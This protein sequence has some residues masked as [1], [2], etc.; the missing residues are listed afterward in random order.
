M[1]SAV[2]LGGRY[3]DVHEFCFETAKRSD[4]RLLELQG[5]LLANFHQLRIV[6]AKRSDKFRTHLQEGQFANA[7]ETRLQVANC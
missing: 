2:L 6:A 3:I 4:I 5:C 1:G 7:Q